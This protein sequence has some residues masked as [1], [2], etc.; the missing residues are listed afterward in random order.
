MAE[1]GLRWDSTIA[2]SIGREVTTGT[3]PYSSTLLTKVSGM[4]KCH[5]TD[6]ISF[7]KIGRYSL[8]DRKLKENEVREVTQRQIMK[9]LGLWTRHLGLYLIGRM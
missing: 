3:Y 4:A 5:V 7:L 2:F 8:G 1:K 9:D 6:G